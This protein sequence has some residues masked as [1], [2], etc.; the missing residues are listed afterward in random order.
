MAVYRGDGYSVPRLI[1]RQEVRAE[2]GHI[3]GYSRPEGMPLCRTKRIT[4]QTVRVV[5]RRQSST[6][7]INGGQ[8]DTTVERLAKGDAGSP[9]AGRAAVISKTCGQIIL[10]IVGRGQVAAPA[11][12]G[13][14]AVFVGEA[15]DLKRAA[16]TGFAFPRNFFGKT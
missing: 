3:R 15:C 1:S 5:R 6:E 2:V 7:R 4:K 11:E 16:R 12:D 10:K 8:F 14:V 13:H 9:T